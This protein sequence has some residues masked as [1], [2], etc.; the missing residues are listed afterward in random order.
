M[1]TQLRI[2]RK[3]V[4]N[5]SYNPWDDT[6]DEVEVTEDVLQYREVGVNHPNCKWRDVPIVEEK[7]K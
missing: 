4:I 6:Y 7:R 3:K 5:V 2:L 1:S